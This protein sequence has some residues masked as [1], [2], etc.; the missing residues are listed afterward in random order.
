MTADNRTTP[1]KT[2]FYQ[3][4]TFKQPLF[5]IAPGIP[6]QHARDQASELL[7]CVRDLTL[8]AVMDNDPQLIW[9][10]HY[11]SALAKALLDDAELG[12]G[13]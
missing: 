4:E 5:Q 1:G 13:R 6:C 3:G 12:M 7:G 8:T 9:A 10:A 2:C 11:L